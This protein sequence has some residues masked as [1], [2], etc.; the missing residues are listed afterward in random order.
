M[1]RRLPAPPEGASHR[2]EGPDHGARHQEAPRGLLRQVPRAAGDGD[3]RPPRR[4]PRAAQPPGVR[5][6]G[7]P[8]PLRGVD[9]GRR[10]LH[11]PDALR[12]RERLAH[13]A[14]HHDRRRE[15]GVGQ[16][17]HRRRPLLRLLP[18]GPQGR[19]PGA[20]QRQARSQHDQGGG[21]QPHRQRR[22]PLGADPGLLRRPGRPPPGHAGHRGL[23]R[24]GVRWRRRGRLPRHRA[25]QDRGAPG[26]AHRRRPRIGVQAA[27]PG[28]RPG[29]GGHGGRAGAPVRPG[30]RHDRHRQHDRGRRRHPHGER[31]HRRVGHGHPRRA[32]GPG[33]RPAQELHG[34]QP[35]RRDQHAAA[36]PEKQIDKIE[37]LSVAKIIADAIDAVFEDTSV[38]EIFG[39]QNQA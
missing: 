9:P 11:H 18:P 20:D 8:L 34:H 28:R 25:G 14:V 33:H 31:R 22:P 19:G 39:G 35:R 2:D 12:A 23:P 3:R 21:R 24:A 4:D 26:A 37:V 15:A 36:A 30:R 5:Q 10:R 13:G 38:S 7:D 6:R 1:P 17:D 29:Q 32:L 16:A 27:Q